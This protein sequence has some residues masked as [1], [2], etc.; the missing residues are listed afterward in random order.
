MVSSGVKTMLTDAGI[1]ERIVFST[2]AIRSAP[3]IT[4]STPPFPLQRI[5]SSGTALLYRPMMEEI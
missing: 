5:E 3:A 2:K 1:T 4:A